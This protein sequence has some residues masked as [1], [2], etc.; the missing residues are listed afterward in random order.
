VD[1]GSILLHVSDDG[2]GL[3]LKTIL[4]SGLKSGALTAQSSEKEIVESLFA[5]GVSTAP[6]LSL[7]AGRGVGL[8]AVRSVLLPLGGTVS[9][10]LETSSLSIHADERPFLLEIRIPHVLQQTG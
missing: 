4:A 5:G 3:S 1:G 8:R 9:I 6:E 10:R 7:Y 2:R